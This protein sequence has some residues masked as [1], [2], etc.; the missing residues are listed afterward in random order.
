MLFA[1]VLKY[2]PAVLPIGVFN[3]CVMNDRLANLRLVDVQPT[4][5]ENERIGILDRLPVI[6]PG[7]AVCVARLKAYA[8]EAAFITK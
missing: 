7:H 3:N 6:N 1:V 4:V 5:T 2:K 8:M